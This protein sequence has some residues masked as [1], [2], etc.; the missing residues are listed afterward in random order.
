MRHLCSQDLARG[1]CELWSENGGS[2]PFFDLSILPS[3][4]PGTELK[5]ELVELVAV[6]S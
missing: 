5:S 6:G 2:G 4:F 3:E 1:A